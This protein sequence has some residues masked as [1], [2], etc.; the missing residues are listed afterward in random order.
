MP[1]RRTYGPQCVLC[2][3]RDLRSP[4]SLIPD[5]CANCHMERTSPPPLLSYDLSGTNHTFRA[6]VDICVACH[7]TNQ[8]LGPML[9]KSVQAELDL[10][11]AAIANVIVTRS[12]GSD[13][14]VAVTSSGGR[15]LV[16]VTRRTG[17]HQTRPAQE[18]RWE[19]SPVLLWPTLAQ[20]ALTRLPRHSGTIT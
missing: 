18:N 2:G 8:A 16:F 9:Q 4:H 10:L 7:G 15:G 14:V 11:Q 6:S 3:K 19:A 20:R 12:T 13:P 17:L 5:T 1:G